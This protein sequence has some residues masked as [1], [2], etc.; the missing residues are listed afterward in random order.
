LYYRSQ[1]QLRGVLFGSYTP[2]TSALFYI[3]PLLNFPKKVLNR[4]LVFCPIFFLINRSYEQGC[5]VVA[6]SFAR[7]APLLNFPKKVLNRDFGRCC[8]A[9]FLL[10]SHAKTIAETFSTLSK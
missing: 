3:A 8:S 7:A 9:S 10:S 1:S 2:P 4:G 6:S 5:C